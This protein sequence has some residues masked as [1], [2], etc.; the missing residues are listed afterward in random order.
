ME[1]YVLETSNDYACDSNEIIFDTYD[2]AMNAAMDEIVTVIRDLRVDTKMEADL[3]DALSE[4]SDYITSGDFCAALNAYNDLPDQGYYN[5]TYEHMYVSVSSVKIGSRPTRKVFFPS[6]KTIAGFSPS[7]NGGTQPVRNEISCPHCSRK[8][9][10]GVNICWYC[11]RGGN[12][13]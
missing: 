6:E 10:V 11:G 1:V 5:G 7:Y 13:C 8:N 12:T 9:D 4:I 2:S 3:V